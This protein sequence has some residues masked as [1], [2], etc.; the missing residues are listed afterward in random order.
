MTDTNVI[1]MTNVIELK[2]LDNNDNTIK[3]I[4]NNDNDNNLQN[5]INI[6]TDSINI[7]ETQMCNSNNSSDVI[8]N[9]DKIYNNNDYIIDI[10]K[11][12]IPKISEFSIID[13]PDLEMITNHNHNHHFNNFPPEISEIPS[14]VTFTN[15]NLNDIKTIDRFTNSLN[16]SS[17]NTE[18]DV[19]Y[20]KQV[21]PLV[22]KYN[23][24]YNSTHNSPHNSPHNYQK[25]KRVSKIK[26]NK[27][28]DIDDF[29]YLYNKLQDFCRYMKINRTNYI[30][31]IC[32]AIE[33]I[34]NYK[35]IKK[36]N[37]KKNIVT[38]ALNRLIILDL[39]LC[40]FDK[41]LF[42]AT[43]NNIIDLIIN[44][45]KIKLH[46]ND[47][48]QNNI[49]DDVLAKSGQIMHSLVDK[50]TTIVIKKQYCLDK[51]FA[52]IST[53]TNIVMILVDKYTYLYGIEKKLIVTQVLDIF[54]KERLQS[55]LDI[56]ETKKEEFIL[57]LDTVPLTIDLIITLQKGKYKINMKNEV[58]NTN[59]INKVKTSSFWCFK[60]SNQQQYVSDKY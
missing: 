15:L 34:E 8:V 46:Q 4:I 39:D 50:L 52:N 45:T 5:N 36:F 33:I 43:I 56:S 2:K 38:K 16:I 29:D 48:Q 11:D 25:Q 3:N 14:R 22:N 53:L 60:S 57:L 35:D 13:I 23:S 37:T 40:L 10:N 44:C 17:N 28:D 6:I 1:D 32:K 24:T 7:F 26:S 19:S 58:Y 9:I 41:T 31:I 42:I 49:T 47:K 21:K 18:S 30:I 59:N 20:T 55:I 51:I 54:I 12:V 27:T